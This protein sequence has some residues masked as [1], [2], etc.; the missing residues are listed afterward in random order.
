VPLVRKQSKAARKHYEVPIR[1]L[2]HTARHALFRTCTHR[3]DTRAHARRHAQIEHTQA[4][5]PASGQ[6]LVDGKIAELRAK[7]AGLDAL[8]E[9]NR[10]RAAAVRNSLPAA[11]CHD[12]VDAPR[13]AASSKCGRS[14][15][16]ATV[17]S[18]WTGWTGCAGPTPLVG[19]ASSLVALL[20]GRRG[21]R[22]QGRGRGSAR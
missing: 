8:I 6:V 4:R 1:L 19:R 7:V 22:A 21:R 13:R 10:Q 18:A 16:V 9:K 14:A 17:L 3:V 12:A 20:S 11:A 5:T 2:L 15:A